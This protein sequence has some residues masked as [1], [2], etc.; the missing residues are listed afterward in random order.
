M[1]SPKKI[2]GIVTQGAKDFGCIQ[3]V[4][5]FKVALS[6]DGKT[7]TTVKDETT[8]MDRVGPTAQ[9]IQQTSKQ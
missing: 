5:A 7:W 1:L 6:N 2:T 4:T 9:N 3:F 8:G